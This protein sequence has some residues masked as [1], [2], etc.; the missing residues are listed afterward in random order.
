MK[1]ESFVGRACNCLKT[2]AGA[3][4]KT[5]PLRSQL[6]HFSVS[7]IIPDENQRENNEG[8]IYGRRDKVKRFIA[9]NYANN[10]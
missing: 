10:F 7:S 2:L 4:S 1:A 5:F 9:K 6:F 3:T 8:I